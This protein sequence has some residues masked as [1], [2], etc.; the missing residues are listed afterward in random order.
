MLIPDRE[1]VIKTWEQ[2]LS[3]D[4]LDAPPVLSSDPL[5]APLD[6]MYDTLALLKELEPV[7]RCKDC[8]NAEPA[9]DGKMSRCKIR[10]LRKNDWF[11]ADGERR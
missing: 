7:V 8:K 3:N 2:V 11:C 1:N 4:P 10:G 5:D 6:L 9:F